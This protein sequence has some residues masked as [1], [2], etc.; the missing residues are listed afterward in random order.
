MKRSDIRNFFRALHEGKGFGP[1]REKGL[2]CHACT[3]I[4]KE[5]STTCE[6]GCASETEI[7]EYEETAEG[8]KIINA[9][10]LIGKQH[11]L[12]KNKDGKITKQDFDMLRRDK[13]K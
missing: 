10:E 8:R 6:N 2:Y 11:K 9:E 3:E 12:D 4:S 13:K 5:G 1:I 7:V